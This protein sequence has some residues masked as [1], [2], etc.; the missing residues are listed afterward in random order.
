MVIVVS[1]LDEYKNSWIGHL[2]EILVGFGVESI[3]NFT[4]NDILVL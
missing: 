3:Y 1:E 4:H 2:N